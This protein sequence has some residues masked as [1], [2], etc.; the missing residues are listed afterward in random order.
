MV[1]KNN[2]QRMKHAGIAVIGNWS[3]KAWSKFFL[4]PLFLLLLIVLQVKEVVLLVH[5]GEKTV[6]HDGS[7]VKEA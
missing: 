4:I 2:R 1:K 7:R 5:E 3:V 6:S